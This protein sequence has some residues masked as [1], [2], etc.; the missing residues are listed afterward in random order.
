VGIN[1]WAGVKAPPPPPS[2]VGLLG[3]TLVVP[4]EDALDQIGRRANSRSLPFKKR[5]GIL[6]IKDPSANP[7]RIVIERRFSFEELVPPE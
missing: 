7:I 3:F 1:V 4:E 6:F 2:A 5:G